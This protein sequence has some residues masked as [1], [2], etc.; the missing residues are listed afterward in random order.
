MG[1]L[2]LIL[3]VLAVVYAG[4][5]VAIAIGSRQWDLA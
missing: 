3:I 5:I 1:W 4:L 2:G